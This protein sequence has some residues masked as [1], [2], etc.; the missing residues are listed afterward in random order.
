MT[1]P[2]EEEDIFFDS[3][4]CIQAPASSVPS[5]LNTNPDVNFVDLQYEM[6]INELGSISERRRRFL[7]KTGLN[8]LRP[9]KYGCSQEI[10]HENL[11]CA[12]PEFHGKERVAES[13]ETTSSSWTGSNY[14]SK[15]DSGSRETAMNNPKEF[16]HRG[17]PHYCCL[18][19]ATEGCSSSDYE[20][21][22]S[23]DTKRKKWKS[24]WK[25]FG[26]RRPGAGAC[27]CGGPVLNPQ[28]AKPQ[29]I[30]VR[31]H[32]KMLMEFAGLNMGQE[33]QAHKGCIQTMKFSPDGQYLATGGEDG[34]VRIWH[35]TEALFA[36]KPLE[37][38]DKMS[39]ENS[40]HGRRKAIH[41]AFV[42]P[43]KMFKI[44]EVP[45]QELHGHTGAVLDLSWSNSN[46][47]LSSSEDKT[48]RMWEVGRNECLE[49]FH[50]QD[51][52]TCIQFNPVDERYFISG[53]IDGKI[54][55]WAVLEKRVVDWVD[56]RDMVTTVCYQPDGQGVIVGSITGHCSF[57]IASSETGNLLELEARLCFQG[58]K[59]STSKRI[60]GLQFSHEDQPKLMVT[61][62]DS[63]MRILDG[64]TVIC[65]YRGI[66]NS[67]NQ[68]SASFTSSG[69]HIISVGEDSHI[70]M[71][72]YN[73]FAVASSQRTRS[74]QSCEYF[75]SKA[76]SVAVPWLGKKADESSSACFGHQMEGLESFSLD[77]CFS[78][79][80]TL[81]NFATW[82]EEKLPVS[83]VMSE[84][85]ETYQGSSA[86]MGQVIVTAGWD[87]V[88][89]SFQ[90]YGL[91]AQPVSYPARML[92][93]VFGGHISMHL[94]K[95]R[96]K[97]FDLPPC[98]FGSCYDPT[99]SKVCVSAN[100]TVFE[101]I[102]DFLLCEEIVCQKCGDIGYVEDLV[103]CDECK[104]YAEHS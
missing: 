35:V 31:S 47:L 104:L 75:M 58:E 46:C 85:E 82:P 96:R 2:Y 41:S 77:G 14:K 39:P 86:A 99:S 100:V 36:L 34:V 19:L 28:I 37:F 59:N 79:D 68:T 5:D 44:E 45:A 42:I 1:I 61:S 13:S 98:V 50:H 21:Q 54:R 20:T 23:R 32:K 89:R 51:Y 18:K 94:L 43:E 95:P 88:I 73:H 62:A 12:D 56:V 74:V 92:S 4:D 70:Y 69:R 91:P 26:S 80:K 30:R 71:W 57:Y 22:K 84:E 27:N 40:V 63:R 29:R 103:Y 53:S 87:G 8:D 78:F 90:N 83:I 65:K 97:L 6:W 7:H 93:S 55:V 25:L 3:L 38:L 11:P 16:D 17:K 102:P 101:S 64:L 33:I 81:K 60:T 72:N 52:V 15:K 48:V 76:V 67:G 49:V 24:F 66:R 10:D 9:S